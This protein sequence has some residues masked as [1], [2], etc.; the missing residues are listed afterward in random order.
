MVAP[1]PSA[2]ACAFGAVRYV[3]PSIQLIPYRGDFLLGVGREFVERIPRADLADAIC[4]I[5]NEAFE[6]YERL[7]RKE[8]KRRMPASELSGI[9]LDIKL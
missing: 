8:R 3:V 6:D 9:S 7:A 1:P 5:F 2:E 4:N